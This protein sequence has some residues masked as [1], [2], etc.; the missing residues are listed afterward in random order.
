MQTLK[1]SKKESGNEEVF[2]LV[3]T[4][5]KNEISKERFDKSLNT[6]VQ[7]HFMKSNT[8]ENRVCLCLPKNQQ[9]QNIDSRENIFTSDID[10]NEEFNKFKESSLEQFEDLKTAFFTEINSYKNY[11]YYHMNCQRSR[12]KIQKLLV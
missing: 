2:N 3:Q 12:Y 5:L 8:V 11:Y 10:I 6:F 7:N 9:E 1:R 4:S